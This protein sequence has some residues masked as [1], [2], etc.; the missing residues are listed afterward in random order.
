MANSKKICVCTTWGHGQDG[1][2]G[3]IRRIKGKLIRTEVSITRESVKYITK[4]L[5][6]VKNRPY[7]V[8]NLDGKTEGKHLWEHL[9]R[10]DKLREKYRVVAFD[11]HVNA[12]GGKG[13]E[14]YIP[15]KNKYAREIAT[16]LMTR[17]KEA[18]IPMHSHDGSVK[19]AI[20]DGDDLMFIRGQY[21]C[22]L[23]E[24]GYIDSDDYYRFDTSGELQKMND[25]I[26][27]VLKDY[28]IK[29]Q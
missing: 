19:G 22:L 6:A 9:N 27:D 4:Q 18:G 24:C 15:S 16:K 11:Y 28:C 25:I 7:V 14:I 5:K 3:A 10:L 21:P 12:G 17:L 2:V 13:A 23:F 26:V 8:E 29:Y 20:K 1:D